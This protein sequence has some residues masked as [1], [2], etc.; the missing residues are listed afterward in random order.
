MYK[1]V[2]VYSKGTTSKALEYHRAME[3]LRRNLQ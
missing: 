1:N 3:L 2:L